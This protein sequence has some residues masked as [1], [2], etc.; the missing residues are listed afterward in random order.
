MNE[1]DIKRGISVIR[2]SVKNLDSRPGIY[3]MIGSADEILYIGKAKNLAKRVSQYAHVSKLPYRLKRMVSLLHK[4]DVLTTKTETQALILESDLIK[5]TQ[6]KYNVALKDDKSF[7][8]LALDN[9]HDFPKMRKFR[10]KKQSNAIYYGPFLSVEKL[11]KTI[12]E[13]QKLF[14]IRNCS[15]HYFATRKR[16]CL[17][18]QIKRCSAPCVG[19]IT[20]EGYNRSINDL[21][22]FLAGKTK[23]IHT[24]FMDEMHHF[25]DKLEY[26][27]AA[28]IRDKIRLLTYI[29]SKNVFHKLAEKNIDIFIIHEEK[30]EQ[31]F[32]IQVF[33][34]R[35]GHNFGSKLQ[36]LDR[37]PG[38]FKDEALSRYIVQFYQNKPIPKEIWSNIDI[39]DTQSISAV[40]AK[41]IKITTP[42]TGEKKNVIEFAL[43]NTKDAYKQYLDNNLAK[44][45]I[46]NEL[47]IKFDLL[48]SPE[49]IE[50]YDNSHNHG[51]Y[52][53]GC[54][55]AVG[56]EG[57][58]KNAYRKY[59]MTNSE[60]SMDD[61]AMLK[62]VMKRRFGKP[63]KEIRVPD[64]IIID[65]GKGQLSAVCS[66]LEKLGIS[67]THVIAMSKGPDRN[68]GREFFHQPGRQAFQLEKDSKLLLFLQK[69][70]DE[71]HRFAITSHRKLIRQSVQKSG[72]DNIKGIG[73]K[74]K[75]IL[76]SHFGS[77]N[78]LK[79]ASQEDIAKVKGLNQKLAKSIFQYISE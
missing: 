48:H 28:S 53:V 18:Y 24:N 57:F 62:E 38:V 51:S 8:Y 3:K 60:I 40:L 70:R 12:V 45:E 63:S 10:G 26:E 9:D 69:I 27:K 15:D 58:I 33:M 64:L 13:L 29:Q 49:T 11:D 22:L 47:A 72:L 37:H 77:I 71:A 68:A 54:M 2:N 25:S 14:L 16:P 46:F 75:K 17:M 79:S 67:N 32:C 19:K 34:V 42:K 23:K 55:I 74:R 30:N 41:K 78:Q 43:D 4:I 6:P 52:A 35:D 50:V 66:E 39:K 36:F 20:K 1:I 21:K 73:D 5:T 44:A 7:A 61:F 76:L 59:S 65:G 56:Q 31:E